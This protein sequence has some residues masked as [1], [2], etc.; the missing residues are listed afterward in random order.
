M[1]NDITKFFEEKL[2]APL[3]NP[4]WSWGALG[5]DGA[6]YL[7]IWQDRIERRNGKLTALVRNG[8]WS[9]SHGFPERA[10]HLELIQAGC[11]CYL[12]ECVAVDVFHE[13]RTIK[14]FRDRGVYRGGALHQGA[15]HEVWI[16]LGSWVL[17]AD[18][19]R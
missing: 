9:N 3:A 1:K 11:P 8:Q 10:R 7:R 12:V 13:P 6:V 5:A 14:S 15:G 4:R 19:P 2:K 17:L 16:E 18:L